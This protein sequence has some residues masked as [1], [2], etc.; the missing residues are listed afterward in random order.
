VSGATVLTPETQAGAAGGFGG[1]DYGAALAC[2]AGSVVTG[3]QGKAGIVTFGG[4]VVDTLGV[5]CQNL[6]TGAVFTSTT[7]GNDAGGTTPYSISC[8]AGK[9]GIGIEGGQ[10]SLLDRIALRCQ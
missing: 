10:G 1:N 3:L 4:N 8:P 6:A 5:I 9:H 2:P 7:V